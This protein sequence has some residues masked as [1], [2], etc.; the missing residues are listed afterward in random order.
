MSISI[1][2]LDRVLNQFVMSLWRTFGELTLKSDNINLKNYSVYSTYVDAG[3]RA[4][5]GSTILVRDNSLYS[6]VK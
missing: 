2:D 6:Y 5:G 4:A 1:V 3:E